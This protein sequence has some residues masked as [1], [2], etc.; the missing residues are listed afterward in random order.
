MST[1]SPPADDDAPLREDIRLLGRVLGDTLRAQEGDAA[2]EMIERIRS[3]AVSSRRIEDLRA[4]QSLE[5]VLNALSRDETVSVVRAFSYFS[6]LANIA[7]DH[8]LARRR[9]ATRGDAAPGS[10]AA[11]FTRARAEGV[12]AAALA[13]FF[14]GALI[15]PVLTAHPTEVQRQAILECERRIAAALARR[16][17][18]ALT[19]EERVELDF[20]LRR[21]VLT[22]WRTRMLRGVKLAVRDEIENG[23]GY[24]QS[25][26][27]AEVPRLHTG[28]ED[29]LGAPDAGAERGLPARGLVDRRRPR[30]QS[31]RHRGDAAL[32][33]AAPVGSGVRPLPRRGA[34]TWP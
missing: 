8:H 1:T 21:Q 14:A 5:A 23:L 32:R 33:G 9:R 25:T 31:L 28:I 7:E 13:G 20:D 2:F 18:A 11:A 15:A 3:L 26:F 17:G 4:R 6:H 24:F 30:R 22:L 19:A 34:R 12:D 27:L 16:D 29:A 10:L